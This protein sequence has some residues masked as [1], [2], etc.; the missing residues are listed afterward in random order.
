MLEGRS[1]QRICGLFPR[2]VF[3]VESIAV[4]SDD[5]LVVKPIDSEAQE[6]R[7]TTLSRDAPL[8][9]EAFKPFGPT[10]SLEEVGRKAAYKALGERSPDAKRKAFRGSRSLP[11]CSDCRCQESKWRATVNA[12]AALKPQGGQQVRLG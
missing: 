12:P 7:P 6:D 9:C 1:R 2:G 11:S 5:R 3:R 10:F 4:G 8:I